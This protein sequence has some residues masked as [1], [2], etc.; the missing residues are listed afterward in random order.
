[1]EI[2]A[3]LHLHS[4]YSRA[5]SPQMTLPVMIQFAK[6][7]GLGLLTTGD[8]TH[9]LWMREIK[10]NLEESE[11]GIY[12]LKSS[13]S[14][15]ASADKQNSKFGNEPKF[16][17]TVEVSSIYSQGGKVRRIH[18][19]LFA[20]SIEV[21]ERMNAELV[22]RG[23]NVHSDGRPI[24][25]LTPR[26]LLEI[27][28]GL[29][30]RCFLIPCHAWTPWFSLYGSMSGFDS[31]DECFGDYSKYIYG[32]ETGLSSDPSMNWRIKELE[33]RSIISS[34][35][36]HSPIKMG[37]ESTVFVPKNGISNFK[38][39]I[40]NLTY[41]DIRLAIMQDSKA[42]LKI[43]Y[44]IEFYPEEGKYH[45]TG[46]RNCKIVYSPEETKKKGKICPVCGK[47][48]TV[49]VMERVEALAGSAEN[50]KNQTGKSGVL[51]ITDPRKIHPPFAKLVPLNE[52]IAETLGSPATSLKVKALFDQLT[53]TL[54]SEFEILLKIPVDDVEKLAGEKLAGAILKV[55]NGKIFIAPGYDGEYGVV[56]IESVG[57]KEELQPE[58]E[59]LF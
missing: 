52:I 23:C 50:I 33:T 5:V 58:Q 9:P 53:N 42:K 49:G 4:K 37:R 28:M 8:W 7:K 19:L 24:V 15:K 59:A 54:G 13:A 2:I 55:R 1:M 21:A 43:G 47:N 6:Q 46:H 51:W 36:S 25:G 10:Q 32:I 3:D 56:K 48:L 12:E 44:T 38:F 30:E 40:S 26:N 57:K 35:D 16:I 29:D 14:A 27:L 20:P 41:D 31:I 18:S 22:K 34:S 11:Q 39:Q 17:L 45:Y